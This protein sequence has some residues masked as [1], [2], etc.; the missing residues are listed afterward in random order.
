MP[1]FLPIAAV[2]AILTATAPSSPPKQLRTIR[3]EQDITP[4]Q[5]REAGRALCA[6]PDSTHVLDV[7][8]GR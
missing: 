8:C 1:V 5:I 6:K 4:A 3:V 7:M 2:I